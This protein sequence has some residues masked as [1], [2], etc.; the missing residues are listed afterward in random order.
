MVHGGEAMTALE[1][2]KK[3]RREHPQLWREVQNGTLLEASPEFIQ[4]VEQLNAP[5]PVTIPAE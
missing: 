1:R 2:D 3:L 5:P 4:A